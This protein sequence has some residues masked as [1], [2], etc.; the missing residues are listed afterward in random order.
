[1]RMQKR[2][3]ETTNMTYR[4]KAWMNKV[5]ECHRHTHSLSHTQ[6][7]NKISLMWLSLPSCLQKFS[8]LPFV[9]AIPTKWIVC[10]LFRH[11]QY[12]FVLSIKSCVRMC[13]CVC[14]TVVWSNSR[15]I[16]FNWVRTHTLPFNNLRFV[17]LTHFEIIYHEI[18]W[19]HQCTQIVWL[20]G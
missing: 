12:P 20:A 9:R 14:V 15:G 1:M 3:E 2:R 7:N 11:I 19:N 5:A 4:E 17:S 10:V 16:G 6:S 18:K 8:L 13:V